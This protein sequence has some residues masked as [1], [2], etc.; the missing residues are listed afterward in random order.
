[1]LLFVFLEAYEISWQKAPSIMGMLFRMYK[2][3]KVNVFL[4]LLRQPTFIFSIGFAMLS[5]YN[6]Y[7]MI[8]LFIKTADIATKILLLEKVFNKKEL[9]HEMS[10]ILIAPINSFIPYIGLFLYPIL[11]LLSF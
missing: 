3:Y 10:M 6:I 8:L 4:F 1:M 9:S 11:I 2:H 7:A 5:E